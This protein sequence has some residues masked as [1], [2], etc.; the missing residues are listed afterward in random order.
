MA[1]D[2]I[3]IDIQIDFLSD[4]SELKK[5]SK[6]IQSVSKN[7][8]KMVKG[9]EKHFDKLDS[10]LVSTKNHL[11][12]TLDTIRQV[13][14][15]NEPFDR[16]R[17]DAQKYIATIERLRTQLGRAQLAQRTFG[18]ETFNVPRFR[19]GM[20]A[21]RQ[22]SVSGQAGIQSQVPFVMPRVGTQALQ[23]LGK[24][25]QTAGDTLSQTFGRKIRAVSE[26][27]PEMDKHLRK[28]AGGFQILDK[29]AREGSSDIS[30]ADKVL[31]QMQQ[32][33]GVVTDRL[34]AG[35]QG[36][37]V[38]DTRL[39]GA[40]MSMKTL[41]PDAKKLRNEINKQRGIWKPTADLSRNAGR[42]LNMVSNRMNRAIPVVDKLSDKQL[43][44][45]QSTDLSIDAI[46]RLSPAAT[47]F[48]R[49]MGLPLGKMN[50]F[51]AGM[52]R[53]RAA[54]TRIGA[55]RETFRGRTRGVAGDLQQAGALPDLE[56]PQQGA[57]PQAFRQVFKQPELEALDAKI[58]RVSRSS[59]IMDQR[60]SKSAR[61]LRA[62]R[63]QNM[64]AF[65]DKVISRVRGFGR[66]AGTA[67][68]ALEKNQNIM[69]TRREM[70]KLEVAA[71]ST[72]G[73]MERFGLI[74][75]DGFKQIKN[76]GKGLAG[77]VRNLNPFTESTRMST[78][79]TRN[80]GDSVGFASARMFAFIGLIQA[81]TRIQMMFVE[82]I[83]N[84]IE[85][86]EEFELIKTVHKDAIG[87]T[88]DLQQAVVELSRSMGQELGE[89]ATSLRVV[90]GQVGSSVA[91]EAERMAVSL[92]IVRAGMGLVETG[93]GELEESSKAV[94]TAL[95]AFADQ[96][97]TAARVGD[98]FAST[99]IQSAFQM[100]D[101]SKN[102]DKFL[103]PARQMGASIEDVVSAFAAM[104]EAGMTADRAATALRN[105][106][107]SF[108]EL[109]PEAIA[110]ARQFGVELNQAVVAQEG[111]FGVMQR[112]R[113][114]IGEVTGQLAEAA[115]NTAMTDKQ[116]IKLAS[117]LKGIKLLKTLF[118][119][120]RELR[121]AL[122][123]LGSGFDAWKEFRKT[124]ENSIGFLD[125]F[126]DDKFKKPIRFMMREIENLET[127][128]EVFAGSIVAAFA[129]IVGPILT[130]I[131]KIMLG[132]SKVF[133]LIAGIMNNTLVPAINAVR[134]VW[135]LL[136]EDLRTSLS[137]LMEAAG[138]V[139][140]VIGTM[141][142]S[143]AG[144]S[145]FG[146][147][148]STWIIGPIGKAITTI[149]KVPIIGQIFGRA[150][151]GMSSAVFALGRALKTAFLGPWGLVITAVVVGVVILEKKFG[152]FSKAWENVKNFFAEH[153]ADIIG[154]IKDLVVVFS[155]FQAFL[156][157]EVSLPVIRA[158]ATMV[159]NIAISMGYALDTV[160]EAIGG[161]WGV[162]RRGVSNFL[163]AMADVGDSLETILLAFKKFGFKSKKAW[164]VL[165]MG[166][167]RIVFDVTENIL[168]GFADLVDGIAFLT[169]KGLKLVF[170]TF[171]N[172][173]N[174]LQDIVINS[175]SQILGFFENFWNEL[176]KHFSLEGDDLVELA[177]KIGK[178]IIFGLTNP[179]GFAIKKMID[180]IARFF[181]G[182]EDESESSAESLMDKVMGGLNAGIGKFNDF[183][184][185]PF[186]D[187][188]G[189]MW[190]VLMNDITFE[191]FIE[192]GGTM[193][194]RFVRSIADQFG[195]AA[196]EIE[197]RMNT[198]LGENPERVASLFETLKQKLPTEEDVVG[199][200]DSLANK[201]KNS[202]LAGMVDRLQ[203]T[204]GQV[205]DMLRKLAGFFVALKDSAKDQQQAAEEN[206][207]QADALKDV[208]STLDNK[209][210]NQNITL[211][212]QI[213]VQLEGDM[214]QEEFRRKFLPTISQSLN[215]A[216]A[217]QGLLNQ[218]SGS[219]KNA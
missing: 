153:S 64:I 218:P 27:L 54:S 119:D 168:D 87:S 159:D 219:T 184:T 7:I 201:L 154:V 41:I 129:P 193:L 80:F 59:A 19:P 133:Q 194:G 51:A 185:E 189:A 96:G 53:I 34:N 144:V 107:Q 147:M 45:K 42:A 130:V 174:A 199:F 93:E 37:N 120:K 207:S 108:I 140:G 17:A 62:L 18:A 71:T 149:L 117:D 21:P 97:L 40:K 169:L 164:K 15:F 135:G 1:R 98:I 213:F 101:L 39:E 81:A 163:G 32:S 212:P 30:R 217:D 11:Q 211:A 47:E 186:L 36:L 86:F 76:W 82:G 103:T 20:T 48:A 183:V 202:N 134:D 43:L 176:Q 196:D 105:T 143:V 33:L 8:R 127:S 171:K 172:G 131:N 158:F 16:Q 109:T 13:S 63:Q 132:F 155:D 192:R 206:A 74:I 118:P 44:L 94:T 57:G 111:F 214:T 162:V 112:V 4:T 122:V 121:G 38:Y 150:L 83:R 166:L 58:Q 69:T 79:V 77:V 75:S 88:R 12:D 209:D 84:S 123:L 115:K 190:D 124:A 95:N 126:V 14:T 89:T 29:M 180:G 156:W 182:V 90:M 46:R 191:Q 3:G 195:V 113:K 173:L 91:T 2:N 50:A 157:N 205:Q 208:A 197:T 177:K 104:G 187:Q 151:I 137:F 165:G 141:V 92:D 142:A 203:L 52:E 178:G 102:A 73:P 148:I 204:G 181:T 22:F 200:V 110:K 128:F 170:D 72:L 68:Q 145:I 179:M 106:L 216:A 198:I 28:T 167:V 152:V 10:Q 188:F 215:Q 125:E 138:A 56:L 175:A 116:V 31:N 9:P 114:G 55:I 6:S 100:E 139:A 24:R 49:A 65:D 61:S 66:E 25:A 70:Q 78:N 160:S 146:S 35:S 210:I 67:L 99:M 60:F 85:T 26:Q 136:G 23:G 5:V 161:I